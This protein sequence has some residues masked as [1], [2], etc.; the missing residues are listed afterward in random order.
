MDI[1]IEERD[2]AAVLKLQGRLDANTAVDLEKQL[3][4][5]IEND[6]KAVVLD[7]GTTAYISSAGLRILLTTAKKLQ[8]Q[9]RTFLLCDINTNI[10]EVFK[11]TGF[12]RILQLRDNLNEALNTL[13]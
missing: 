8:S 10:M 6:T 7:F 2:N 5:V 9:Q 12:H 3:L 1:E 13:A 11:M 4:F